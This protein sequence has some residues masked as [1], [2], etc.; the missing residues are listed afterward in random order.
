MNLRIFSY[1][2]TSS[3]TP[4]KLTLNSIISF[5]IQSMF[6]NLLLLYRSPKPI[7]DPTVVYA[8]YLVTHL[9]C[10][11]SSRTVSLLFVFLSLTLAVLRSP[12]QLYM[13]HALMIKCKMNI[14]KDA[15]CSPRW[16]RWRYLASSVCSISGQ[17]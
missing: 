13:S 16:D 3:M 7:L 11:L 12:F 2:I 1:K 6:K 5:N 10:L 4:K 14:I 15:V 8:S 17:C 9:L